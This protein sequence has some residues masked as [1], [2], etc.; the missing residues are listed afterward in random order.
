MEGDKL[1]TDDWRELKHHEDACRQYGC[2]MYEH[3]QAVVSEAEIVPV[4][5]H[6]GKLFFEMAVVVQ[7][8]KAR[9][10]EPQHA[11]SEDHPLI[12][13]QYISPYQSVTTALT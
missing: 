1:V 8:R 5:W 7:V 3:A 2:E 10:G 13:T 12:M 4:S 9:K 6:Q 11:A